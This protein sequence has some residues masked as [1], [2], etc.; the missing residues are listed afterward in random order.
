MIS[1]GRTNQRGARNNGERFPRRVQRPIM[2]AERDGRNIESSIR[3]VLNFSLVTQISHPP[4]DH[5]PPHPFWIHYRVTPAC[6]RC[7]QVAPALFCRHCASFILSGSTESSCSHLTRDI[8]TPSSLNNLWLSYRTH[9]LE[10]F[11]TI[12]SICQCFHEQRE[13][14]LVTQYLRLPS[15]STLSRTDHTRVERFIFAFLILVNSL[16]NDYW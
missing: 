11:V 6:S 2:S 5:W 8:C 12:A 7:G 9:S 15:F 4:H 10:C 13:Y 1:N 3:A 16:K 14:S